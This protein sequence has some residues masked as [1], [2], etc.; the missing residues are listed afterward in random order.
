MNKFLIKHPLISEKATTQSNM[1]KYIFVVQEEATK[2]EV[3][4]LIETLYKVHVIKMN[5]I[6]TAPKKKRYGQRFAM[7]PGIRKMI[8]TI[9][10]GEKIDVAQ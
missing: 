9:K 4:K 2:N 8:V 5:S 6:K 1:S 10:K 7:Q 3:A